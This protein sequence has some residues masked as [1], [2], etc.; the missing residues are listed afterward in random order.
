MPEPKNGLWKV[1][2]VA[3]IS[4][5]AAGACSWLAFGASTIDRGEAVEIVKTHSPYNE[6]RKLL[7]TSLNRMSDA[8]EKQG[9]AINGLSTT[10]AVQAK[11]IGAMAEAQDKVDGRLDKMDGRLDKMDSRL[12]DA[13]QDSHRHP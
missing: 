8:I 9:E 6:D 1:V 12:N 7:T 10:Q 4:L 2:A 5:V 3:L 13:L 11:A